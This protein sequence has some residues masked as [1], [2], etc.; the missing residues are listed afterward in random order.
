MRKHSSRLTLYVNNKSNLLNK[1]S[2]VQLITQEN[3]SLVNRIG[4]WK[5]VDLYIILVF[6]G[7][8][9]VMSLFLITTI[10]CGNPDVEAHVFHLV[11]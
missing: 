2:H 7:S 6:R 11:Q 4:D 9:G 8:E 5:I 1:H 3:I 10:T